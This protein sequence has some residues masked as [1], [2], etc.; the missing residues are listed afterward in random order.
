MARLGAGK[1]D[2]LLQFERYAHTRGTDGAQV[3][4]WSNIEPQVWANVFAQSAS[5]RI[6]SGV[7]SNSISYIVR[8]LSS[9]DIRANDRVTLHGEIAVIRSVVIRSR[10]EK[11]AIAEINA[12]PQ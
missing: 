9:H 6:K 1:R 11:E 3:A 7:T 2:Q 4:T 8:F 5:E 10:A 12:G